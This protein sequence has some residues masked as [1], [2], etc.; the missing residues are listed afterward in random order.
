M[1]K[2][3]RPR[4]ISGR[5]LEGELAS[6]RIQALMLRLLALLAIPVLLY[7]LVTTPLLR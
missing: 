7:W 1:R 4:I 6:L 3:E 5:D 2:G